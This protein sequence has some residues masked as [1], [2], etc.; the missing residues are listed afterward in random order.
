MDTFVT[1]YRW[2]LHEAGLTLIEQLMIMFV[3]ALLTALALPVYKGYANRPIINAAQ[4]DLIRM[5]ATFQTNTLENKLAIPN[6]GTS[7]IPVPALPA[8]RTSGTLAADFAGWVP[9]QGDHFSYSVFSLNNSNSV[10]FTL[11]ATSTDSNI[12][13]TTCWML[14]T[15]SSGSQ[16]RVDRQADASC[17]FTT[18]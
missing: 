1:P 13:P 10:A 17:G 5:A 16:F 11:A 15:S 12:L 8:N 9:T 14:I 2:A 18:W 4:Q 3:V 6:Y 7:Y